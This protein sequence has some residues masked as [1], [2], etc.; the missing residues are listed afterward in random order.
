MAGSYCLTEQRVSVI[1]RNQRKLALQLAAC[2]AIVL[3]A[4]RMAKAARLPANHS[5][6]LKRAGL[7]CA[8]FSFWLASACQTS[9][10]TNN[11]QDPVPYV[12]GKKWTDENGDQVYES[13]ALDGEW[14]DFPG[15][16]T[17]RLVH[18]FGNPTI[19]DLRMQIAFSSTPM[20]GDKAD[21]AFAT[22]DVAVVE[23]VEPDALVIRNNTCSE[24]YIYVKITAPPPLAAD[25]GE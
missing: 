1:L 13:T 5:R 12:D 25:A 21:V 22:G 14:L 3:R 17:F 18:N 9:C 2:P 7:G 11:Y 10:G 4:A 16:R 20:R 8:I 6:W 24:Q 23:K 15:G 19:K